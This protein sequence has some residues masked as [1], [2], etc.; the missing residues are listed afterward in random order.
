MKK[1][2]LIMLSLVALVLGA[3]VLSGCTKA[4]KADATS[5]TD[6]QAVAPAWSEKLITPGTITVGADTNYPPFEAVA[7]SG[8]GFEGFDVDLVA[9]IAQRLGVKS[10]F[11]TYGFDSL[12]AGLNA[13]TDFDMVASAWTI[14]VERQKQVDFSTPYFRNDFGVTVAKD[15]ALTGYAD[16]KK[17]ETVAVQTGSSAHE[18]AKKEL[19]PKGIVLKT[20]EN[21]LDGFNALSTGDVVMVIQDLAMTSEVVKDDARNAK[22]VEKITVDEFFG[23]GFAKTE[24]GAAMKKDFDAQLNAI[25]ADGTYAKIYKKWFGVDPTYLPGDDAQ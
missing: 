8:S 22:V 5:K 15:S 16:L 20:Y 13:G 1:T 14:N 4:T 24:T 10:Q 25:A 9:E 19:A 11:K 17:G 7:K 6:A 12:V 3:L 18:W 2:S 21:T 23:M